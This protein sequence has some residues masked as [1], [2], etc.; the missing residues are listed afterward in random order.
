MRV[1]R[2]GGVRGLLMREMRE[3]QRDREDKRT[4]DRK[5]VNERIEKWRM[6]DTEAKTGE[7]IR[8]M[9]RRN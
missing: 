1:W 3:S 8:E 9:E 6:K 4:R 2:V 7:K 5:K